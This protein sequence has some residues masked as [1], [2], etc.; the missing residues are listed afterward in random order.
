[1]NKLFLE[2]ILGIKTLIDL[3]SVLIHMAS[4]DLKY[5]KVLS[6]LWGKLQK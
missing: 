4:F 1:M 5:N 2:N 3:R 6:S